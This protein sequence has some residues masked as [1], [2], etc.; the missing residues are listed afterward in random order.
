MIGLQAA[1]PAIAGHV[2]LEAAKRGVLLSFCL[3]RPSVLRVYPPAV[4][5][6]Q[7]LA[8]GLDRIAEA[9]AATPPGS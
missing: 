4:I 7:D 3:S 1:S 2:V 8:D 6:D 9:V 5:G